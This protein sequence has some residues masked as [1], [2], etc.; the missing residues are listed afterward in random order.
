[1]AL[2]RSGDRADDEVLHVTAHGPDGSLVGLLSLVPWGRAAVS[3]D[4]MRR[5]LD[6][7]H[8]VTELMVNELLARSRQLGLSRVSLNF[9]MFRA[10][11]E[12]AE[13]L[14]SRSL[15]R[16]GAS[17]L[18]LFDRVWQL[19]RLYRSNK[20][21]DPS[22]QP[23]FLCYDDAVSLP[24]VA[25]AVGAAEGFV[26]YPSLRSSSTE[27]DAEHLA[28]A[29]EMAATS[30]DVDALGPRRSDQF[31]HRAATVERMREAGLDA[32]PVGASSVTTTAL[33]DL[34][35]QS[36]DTPRTLSVVGRVRN[37]RDHGGVVFATLVDG[38]ARLQVLLDAARLGRERLDQFTGFVDVG[39]LV[40]VDGT[41]GVSRSGTRSL[42]AQTW[43][44][45]AKS[46]HPI[47]FG[48]FDD[49]AAKARQRST[50][51]LVHPR[52]VE[53]LR[54]RS[55]V[56]G[57]IRRSL[58][59]AGFLEVETPMLHTTHGGASARPFRTFINAYGVDLS[60]RIAPE[61]Y[62]KRLLVAGLGPVFELGR[63][64]RNEGADATHNPEFTSLEV[65]QPHG[66]YVTM[67]LLA[68]RVVREAARAVHGR[69]VIPVPAP[70]PGPRRPRRR[71]PARHQRR[72]ARRPRARRRLGGRRKHGDDGHRHRRA[73]RHRRGARRPC[74]S[75]DGR[76]RGHRG[77]LRRARRA[78]D[79]AADLLHR[80]PTGDLSV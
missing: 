30:V 61:L 62:L 21:Y 52:D 39:D 74:A 24:Q 19:E 3:L 65:Y 49:P 25:V 42:L 36:W 33:A 2:G 63:N 57:S 75:R 70:G 22:W 58:T 20:K 12:D 54:R 7:P 43:R 10:V 64:F 31:R 66:D 67:R 48:A 1:M 40:R 34:D 28:L 38:G 37:V 79:P 27:L 80:L 69:E 51:L 50:D 17:V 14:G 76:G 15:T 60:L 32:Y 47:P 23:R 8:G 45:E 77:A 16:V 11:F 56:V 26:R 59:D 73:P 78:D 46:L 41:T 72:V 4:V 53:L 18:G 9:C 44:M 6:A 35:A 55:A 68:E 5:A 13:R 71:R 29:A